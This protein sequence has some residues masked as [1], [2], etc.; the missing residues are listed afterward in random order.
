MILRL[1]MGTPIKKKI[2]ILESIILMNFFGALGMAFWVDQRVALL[3]LGV[4]IVASLWLVS[5][6]CPR[7]QKLVFRR[8][9]VVGGVQWNYGGGSPLPNRCSTCGLDFRYSPDQSPAGHL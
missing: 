3:G 6:R 1:A 7:C 9:A 2:I 5:L 4:V 8:Q